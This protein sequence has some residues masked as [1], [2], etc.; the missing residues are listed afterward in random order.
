MQA[1]RIQVNEQNVGV[2]G[3]VEVNLIAPSVPREN[4][5]F[6]NI[7]A[8]ASVEPQ[9]ADVNCQGTWLLTVRERDLPSITFTDA[10]VNTEDR[11]Q[12]II[13]CGVFSA[14]NQMPWNS[15]PISVKTSRNIGPLGRMVMVCTV[16]GITA[17]LASVRVMLCAHT[18]RA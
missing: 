3:Q 1:K 4:V 14:S 13:A 5:N 12:T 15:G 11:N 16:T 17:G 8:S 2:A 6:H 9:N 10:E 18:V 7:W